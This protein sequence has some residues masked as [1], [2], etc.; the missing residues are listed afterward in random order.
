MSQFQLISAI[1]NS[2][3]WIKREA[4]SNNPRMKQFAGQSSTQQHKKAKQTSPNR[5][6][7]YR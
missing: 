7:P 4:E 3:W 5:Y 1:V 6:Y 2:E